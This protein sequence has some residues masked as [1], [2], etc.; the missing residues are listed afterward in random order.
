MPRIARIPPALL[1]LGKRAIIFI[2]PRRC[3]AAVNTRH[4]N[5]ARRATTALTTTPRIFPNR[6]AGNAPTTVRLCGIIYIG[7]AVDDATDEE[8]RV[9]RANPQQRLRHARWAP[10]GDE[11]MG[12]SQEERNLI[13][14]P[15]CRR[16][17]RALR[18]NP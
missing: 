4:Y 12:V 1:R 17:L 5:I 7:D 15:S 2:S 10:P 8:N 3:C 9:K 18:H 14:E 13:I 11:A 16:R 6:L